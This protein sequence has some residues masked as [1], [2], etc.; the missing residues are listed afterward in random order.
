LGV[1]AHELGSH[2]AV[3]AQKVVDD[4][5][6]AVA[7]RAGADADGGHAHRLGDGTGCDG[8][9]LVI[10]DLLGIDGGVAPKFVR[11][12]AQLEADAVAAVTAYAADVRGRRFPSEDE[13]YHLAVDVPTPLSPPAGGATPPAAPRDGAGGRRA[14]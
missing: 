14:S 3:D 4:E 9:V 5:D 11:R 1:A 8:Q 10:H 13:T 7:A 6:L 2:A 12:Y